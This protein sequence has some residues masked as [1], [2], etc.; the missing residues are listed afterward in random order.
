MIDGPFASLLAASTDLGPAR[1]DHVQL[2]AMLHD[3]RRPDALI[4][5]ASQ[6]GLSVQWRTSDGWA[7]VEG[8]PD[9]VADAFGVEVHDYR[10]Q[11]GQEF[12]ASPQ[13]PEVPSPLRDEVQQLGR[14]LSYTPHHESRPRHPAARR[15]RPRTDA[16][17]PCSTPTTRQAWHAAASPARAPRS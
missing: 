13:Q 9:R 15:A 7:V 2:T 10:G 11:R 12:Y 5:W 3:D 17:P 1:G 6:H 8:T 16:R 14:I 4:G